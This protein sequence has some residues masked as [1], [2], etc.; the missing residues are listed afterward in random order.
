MA[1]QNGSARLDRIERAI[2]LMIA[3]HEQ[4][5]DEHKALLRA[6]VVQQDQ[7]D[8]LAAVVAEHSLQIARN[9]EQ[10]ARSSQELDALG[11][12]T[13]ARIDALVSAIAKLVPPG[14]AL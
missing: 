11:R 12:K 13:D 5:R 6:Q 8:R 10:I 2:E 1:E 4:F 14:A 3:D 9:S 7:L